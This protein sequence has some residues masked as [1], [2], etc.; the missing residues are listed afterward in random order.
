MQVQAVFLFHGHATLRRGDLRDTKSKILISDLTAWN[1]GFS[2][3]LL[4]EIFRVRVFGGSFMLYHVKVSVK[5][6]RD[7]ASSGADASF[8]PTARAAVP[9]MPSNPEGTAPCCSSA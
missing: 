4:R 5:G 1:F 9:Q 8:P 3:R 6:H 7:A 2:I